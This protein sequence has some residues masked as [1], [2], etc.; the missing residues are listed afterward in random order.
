[1]TTNVEPIAEL[2][3]SDHPTLKNR[4]YVDVKLAHNTLRVTFRGDVQ[5]RYVTITTPY[6][7]YTA[8]RA[9]NDGL[10]IEAFYLR[11][12][13]YQVDMTLEWVG[14]EG[15]CEPRSDRAWRSLKRADRDQLVSDA[16][17]RDLMTAC[18]VAAQ[19]AA[20]AL[21]DGWRL[22]RAAHLEYLIEHIDEEVGRLSGELSL[23]RA[24]RDVVAR[25]L[26]LVRETPEGNLP[27]AHPCPELRKALR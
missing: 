25:S 1:M 11:G 15:W 18:E 13:P 26:T 3:T 6:R 20:R 2:G 16:A 4:R 17:R 14:L 27:I 9:S 10:T 7:D 21:P 24:D 5:L 22:A 23:L 19:A 12:V 8:V